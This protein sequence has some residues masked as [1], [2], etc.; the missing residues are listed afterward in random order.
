L[1]PLLVPI[2]SIDFI[3]WFRWLRFDAEQDGTRSDS[4]RVGW[5][6]L[7]AAF[8]EASTYRLDPLTVDQRDF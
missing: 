6:E 8:R 4:S 7:V 2:Q 1:V 3:G 5:G